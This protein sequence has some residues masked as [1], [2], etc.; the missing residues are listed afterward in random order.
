MAGQTQAQNRVA[1]RSLTDTLRLHWRPTSIV[2]FLIALILALTFFFPIFFMVTSSFKGENEIFA[3]PIH[4]LPQDFQGIDKYIAAFSQIPLARF[5]F[6]SFLMASIDVIVTVIFSAMAGYGFAKFKFRGQRFLFFCVLATITVPFQILIVPL[7]IQVYNY[8]W[9]DTYAGLI[10][11]GIMNA[12]GVFMMRQ[13]CYAIPD[14]L[15]DAARIDGAGELRIFWQIV[16][17]LLA[18]ASASLAVIIF[19]FSWNNFLWPL[20]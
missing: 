17:P 18:P 16:L 15:L 13:F 20:I 19:L 3:T 12:F 14:E 10:I 2:W 9:A 4:L 8:G 6:N 11:P 5:F 1:R 7:Y